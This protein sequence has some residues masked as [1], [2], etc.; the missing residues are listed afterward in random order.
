MIMLLAAIIQSN[1]NV[2]RLHFSFLKDAAL[3]LRGLSK[4]WTLELPAAS[5]Q[6]KL[7]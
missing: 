4:P 7:E 6:A 5:N 2:T 3:L 1:E